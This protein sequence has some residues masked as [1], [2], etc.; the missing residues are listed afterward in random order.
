[1]KRPTSAQP[2]TIDI[3]LETKIEKEKIKNLLKI[4]TEE[5]LKSDELKR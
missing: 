5:P 1:M 3:K 4:D 2:E